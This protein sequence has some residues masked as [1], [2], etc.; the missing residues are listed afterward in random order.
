[1]KITQCETEETTGIENRRVLEEGGE[2]ESRSNW[3]R[4]K[5]AQSGTAGRV[6][7]WET[8]SS[9]VVCLARWRDETFTGTREAVKGHMHHLLRHWPQGHRRSPLPANHNGPSFTFSLMA[10]CLI[11][12]EQ[13]IGL[14]VEGI[15]PAET[16]IATHFP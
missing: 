11:P 3:D 1:M 7:L 15:P 10:L 4:K 8:L 9:E 14:E 2:V 13:C 16:A 5:K 6:T 12:V